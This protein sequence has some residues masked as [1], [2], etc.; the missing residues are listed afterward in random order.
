M[1]E[2]LL[3]WIVAYG[4]PGIFAALLLGIFGAPIPDEVILS[5]AGYLAYQGTLKLHLAILAAA[6]GSICGISLSYAIGRSFGLY[7]FERYGRY[8]GITPERLGK[9]HDWFGRYGK[10]TLLPG[11]FIPG[12]RHLIAFLAG[13]TRLKYSTFALFA[14]AGGFLWTTTFIIVGYYMGKDWHRMSETMHKHLLL[15]AGIVTVAIL[16]WFLIRRR[17]RKAPS[18]NTA[19]E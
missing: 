16:A 9:A 6:L 13:S 1:K 15:G 5:F 8:V 17:Q 19:E 7:L 18:A 11:F 10:W 12:I 3:H 14:Y 2:L 4:Y